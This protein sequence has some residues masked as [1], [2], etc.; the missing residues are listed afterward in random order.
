MRLP[1]RIRKS[2]GVRV[3]PAVHR[4]IRQGDGARR[5]AH[6]NEAAIAFRAALA[7][8]PRLHHIRLQLGHMLKEAGALDDADAVYAEAAGLCPDDAEPLV[9]RAHLAKRRRRRRA[10]IRLF[11]AALARNGGHDVEVE[12]R[13]ML[14]IDDATP[15]DVLRRI[16]LAACR[17]ADEPM[18]GASGD[19]EADGSRARDDAAMDRVADVRPLV[20]DVTDLVGH[21]RYQRAPTGIQRV[22]IEVLDRA[23]RCHGPA[24]IGIGCFIN[25]RSGMVPVPV[26]QIV[27]LALLTR[28]GG[29]T[30]DPEWQEARTRLLV[31]LALAPHMTLPFRAILVNLGTSLWVSDYFLFIRNAKTRQQISYI[32]FVHDLIPI[33]LPDYCVRD[34]RETFSAWLAGLFHHADGFLANSLSTARDLSQ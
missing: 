21:F 9:H 8:D 24:A 34:I 22:Q 28:Q 32:P 10:A 6:W 12:L 3:T 31:H 2:A 33:M 14:D 19:Q 20:F 11:A 5:H 4:L 16:L 26:D 15:S 25:G 13:D 1:F 23:I 7:A 17:P 18:P 27:A 29:D 30:L